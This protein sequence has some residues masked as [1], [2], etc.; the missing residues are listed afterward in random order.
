MIIMLF[1]I[2]SDKALGFLSTAKSIFVSKG[3]LG[4]YQGVVPYLIGDGLSGAVKFATF[5]ISKV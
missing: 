3:P 1:N 5:E 2:N 4:F